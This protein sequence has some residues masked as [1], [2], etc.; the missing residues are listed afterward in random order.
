MQETMSGAIC[1]HCDRDATRT[2]RVHVA[3]GRM[4]NTYLHLWVCD[5]HFTA[6]QVVPR[7]GLFRL[8]R[9]ARPSQQTP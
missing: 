3:K 6:R 7:R 5:E 2:I 1:V 9:A 8:R 4:S